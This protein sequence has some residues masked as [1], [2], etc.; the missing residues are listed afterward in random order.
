MQVYLIL[1]FG[2]PSLRESSED[3]LSVSML[4]D[5]EDTFAFME[6]R[7]WRRV[8]SDASSFYF[9]APSSSNM[10]NFSLADTVIEISP[11]RFHPHC[12]YNRSFTTHHRNDSSAS[13]SSVGMS[14]VTTRRCKQWNGSLDTSLQG[15]LR[16]FCYE[17]LF[18]NSSWSSWTWRQDAQ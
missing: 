8:E 7:L 11:C 18:R 9:S 17:R 13:S 3:M 4:M 12:L 16:R 6:N 5:I 10:D 15:S 1:D 2:L 14:Y